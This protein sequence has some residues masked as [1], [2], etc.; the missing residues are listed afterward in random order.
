MDHHVA[1]LAVDQEGMEKQKQKQQQL[2]CE[3]GRRIKAAAE[4]GLARSS[5]GRQWGRALGRRALAVAS[6][7]DPYS[8]EPVTAPTTGEHQAQKKAASPEEEEEEEE[9]VE[10][11]VALLR[12]L[13]PGGEDMAVEGL[14][15]ET[16]DYIA[17][18]KAQ[19]GV[20]RAL[21][22]LLSGSGLD[23]LTEKPA[24]LLTPE[25]SRCQ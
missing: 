22:C 19:V 8:F 12:Q 2:V 5:R 18:L 10:E 6:A 24:G 11:K 9:E 20:M 7:K 16:A 15:E 23:E 17:A 21:A 1:I 14:L 25:K 13:V 4:L 3:R